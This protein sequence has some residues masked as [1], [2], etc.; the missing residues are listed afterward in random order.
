MKYS[1]AL[2]TLISTLLLL[3][4]TSL[5]SCY[6][7]PL[8]DHN[9]TPSQNLTSSEWYNEFG[10]DDL[11]CQYPYAGYPGQYYECSYDCVSGQWAGGKTSQGCPEKI[12]E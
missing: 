8:V 4:R 7:C 10:R 12:G 11:I 5:A 6:A 9:Q 3:S 1:V 2:T